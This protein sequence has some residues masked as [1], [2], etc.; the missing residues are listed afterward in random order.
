MT[1]KSNGETEAV[2]AL[3]GVVLGTKQELTFNNVYA[4][5]PLLQ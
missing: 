1:D 2:C 5:H 3:K 4:C